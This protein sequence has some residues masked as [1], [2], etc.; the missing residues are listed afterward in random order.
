MPVPRMRRS[1]SPHATLLDAQKQ[2]PNQH[3]Q[4]TIQQQH[5]QQLLTG[6][7]TVYKKGFP[8]RH[9]SDGSSL[10]LA[11]LAADN[12]GAYMDTMPVINQGDGL[13]SDVRIEFGDIPEEWGVTSN[14]SG[15]RTRG[16]SPEERRRYGSNVSPSHGLEYSRGGD[17]MAPRQTVDTVIAKVNRSVDA[18]LGSTVPV[19]PRSRQAMVSP[20]RDNRQ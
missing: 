4:E 1:P 19:L 6:G 12:I 7:Q 16:Q 10:G 13:S 20:V 9:M 15:G 2:V 17:S 8:Q 3:R 5:N 11:P 18:S 14:T